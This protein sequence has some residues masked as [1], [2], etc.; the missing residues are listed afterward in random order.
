M[1]N[2]NKRA[3]HL[4]KRSRTFHKWCM[5]FLSVQFM[6]WS[7]TGVYMVF[8]D[9]DYIHGD[10][11]VKNQQNT[12][13][14]QQVQV[15]VKDLHQQYGEIESLSLGVFIDKAVYRFQSGERFYLVDARTGKLLSPLDEHAAIYRAKHEYTGTG[16]VVSAQLIEQNPPFELSP[17][18]LPAW[19]VDFDD[20]GA[21]ALYVSA[22]SGEVVTKRHE[23]WRLFDWVFRFHVM[24]Y[25]DSDVGN[26]LLFWVALF[27]ITGGVSGLILTYFRV[28]KP[29]GVHK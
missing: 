7:V 9:I 17:K 29:Q 3:F 4:E 16:N 26:K 2:N 18:R 19:R 23:W 10:S 15:S 8:F 12:I 25:Q 28:L 14:L 22:L 13:P 20:F 6:I 11:L 24:D 21:P 1:K 27:A 5:L